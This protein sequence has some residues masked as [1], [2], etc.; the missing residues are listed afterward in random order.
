MKGTVLIIDDNRQALDSLASLFLR[1][2]WMVQRAESGD[3]ALA[4][5]KM[6]MPSTVVSSLTMPGVSGCDVA[7]SMRAKYRDECPVL[8]ALAGNAESD[9]AKQ[10]IDAGF[11]MVLA[12][13]VDFQHLLAMIRLGRRGQKSGAK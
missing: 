9:I 8:I 10:A 3:E 11:S 6:H 5:A 4:M 12:K 7:R 2:D 13:P 1:N